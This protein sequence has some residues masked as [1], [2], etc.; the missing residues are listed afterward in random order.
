MSAVRP[1]GLFLGLLSL[2]VTAITRFPIPENKKQKK[3]PV[4][5]DTG[6]PAA[7]AA[8]AFADLGGAAGFASYGDTTPAARAMWAMYRDTNPTIEVTRLPAKGDPTIANILVSQVNGDRSI[9]ANGQPVATA[10]GDLAPLNR[11]V[12]I[13]LLD[14]YH[15]AD[16]LPL[17]K[18]LKAAGVC[19]VLDGGSWKDDVAAHS[20]LIDC[21]ILSN[22]FKTPDG[23]DPIAYFQDTGVAHVAITNGSEAIRARAGHDQIVFDP[24]AKQAV[25]TL[26]AGDMFHGA[27][28][29]HYA[30]G[31]DFDASLQRA[32][33]YASDS[34]TYFGL[35]SFF[36]RHDPS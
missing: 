19:I 6:G 36:E 24:P 9:I 4:T 29:Y 31:K 2:D 10:D 18:Q 16:F 5:V 20:D 27:F 30:Q 3:R 28:C 26:G 12:D 33:D 8:R 15:F 1:S 25:D 17:V 14:G 23:G 21:A 34:V 11:K 35:R 32:A 7:N 22:D 13:A